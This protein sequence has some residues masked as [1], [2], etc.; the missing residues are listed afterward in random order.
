[1]DPNTPPELSADQ[2]LERLD[3]VVVVDVRDPGSY[4]RRRI[5]G[6][7]SVLDHNVG[8][9]IAEAD[10]DKTVVVV[11]YHGNSSLGG[12]AYFLHNGFREVYSM[13]GGMADWRGEVESS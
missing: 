7:L 4:R 12:A 5:P 11:C 13:A 1:M 6:A 3:E 10:K 8:Q 2:V 9:F